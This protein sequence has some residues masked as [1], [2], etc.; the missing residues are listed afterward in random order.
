MKAGTMD[1]W[2]DDK[3]EY[4][5]VVMKAGTMDVWLDDKMDEGMVDW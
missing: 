4:L 1:V 3:R 5:W 2:L